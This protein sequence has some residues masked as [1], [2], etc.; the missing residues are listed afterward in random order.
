MTSR[1]R[2]NELDPST[3]SLVLCPVDEHRFSRAD[4]NR[5]ELRLLEATTNEGRNN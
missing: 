4:V 1:N 2:D 5:D 3:E